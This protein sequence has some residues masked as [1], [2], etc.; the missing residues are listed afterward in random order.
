MQV[1]VDVGR[2]S[3]LGAIGSLISKTGIR[4]IVSEIP[5]ASLAL[6]IRGICRVRQSLVCGSFYL[7]TDRAISS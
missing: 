4:R 5:G 7:L 1:R 6:K 2:K 3:P